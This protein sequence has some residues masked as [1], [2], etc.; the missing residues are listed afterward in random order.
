MTDQA[1]IDAQERI[2]ALE[3][4]LEQM[5][6]ALAHAW[7]QLVP[8]LQSTPKHV[9]STRDVIPI[10]ESIMAAVDAPMGAVYLADEQDVQ[11]AQ[12]NAAPDA[13]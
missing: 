9:D 6:G 2:R 11:V 12:A 4:E 13:V 1:L 8:F 7:D 10:L 5:T 3:V